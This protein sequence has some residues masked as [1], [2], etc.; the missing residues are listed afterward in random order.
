MLTPKVTS[1]DVCTDPL[2]MIELIDCKLFQ[3]AL[4]AYNNIIFSLGLYIDKQAAL[5]LLTYRRILLYKSVNPNY[6]SWY[7]VNKISSKVKL[8]I[9]K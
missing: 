6:A 9:N 7:S 4:D 1:C 3:L 8:L 2:E 5:D